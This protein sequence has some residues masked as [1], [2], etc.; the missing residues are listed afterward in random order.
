MGNILEDIIHQQNYFLLTDVDHTYHNPDLNENAGKST[1]DLTL[2]SGLSNLHFRTSAFDLTKT[3]HMAIE[4]SVNEQGKK[5]KKEHP[6][7]KKK[8]RLVHMGKNSGY[9]TKKLQRHFPDNNQP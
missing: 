6:F 5:R 1:T 9:Q 8:C 7:Q 3:Q 2:V 4:I